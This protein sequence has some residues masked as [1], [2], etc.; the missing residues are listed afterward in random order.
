MEIK[1]IPT[2]S[3]HWE[4]VLIY[5]NKRDYFMTEA[6]AKTAASVIRGIQDVANGNVSSLGSFAQYADIE[7]DD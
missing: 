6:E 2:P 5:S 3:G 4:W 7:T 1:H